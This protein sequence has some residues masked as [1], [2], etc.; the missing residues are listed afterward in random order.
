MLTLPPLSMSE[1]DAKKFVKMHGMRRVVPI[2]TRLFSS[3]LGLTVEDRNEIGRWAYTANGSMPNLYSDEANRPR[4]I[5]VREKVLS[6]ARRIFKKLKDYTGMTL[7]DSYRMCY[8]TG[9]MTFV[10]PEP[11]LDSEELST[12]ECGGESE[13]E[14]EPPDK[15]LPQRQGRRKRG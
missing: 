7:D 11:G 8:G 1:A 9:E 4:Q 15:G 5:E 14:E 3:Q 12:E 6:R 13:D 2:L 10:D